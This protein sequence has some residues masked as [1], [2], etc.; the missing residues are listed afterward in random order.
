MSSG[1]DRCLDDLGTCEGDLDTCSGDL[2][3]CDGDLDTCS[4]DLGTCE[5]D[6]DTCSG[7]LDTCSGDLGTCEGDLGTCSGDLDACTV[8]VLDADGDGLF[9]Q[10]DGCPDT[11][12]GQTIDASG[13]SHGQFCASLAVPAVCNNGD[14]QNDE[15]LGNA[16]DCKAKQ[17]T[18][19]PR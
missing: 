15:P 13:C 7:D 6:L 2:G 17:G 19:M 3:T 1:L 12:P 14:W 4:G 8:Q 9:D 16:Q 11:P 18:C 5:G 10:F